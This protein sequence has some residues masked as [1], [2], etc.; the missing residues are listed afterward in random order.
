MGISGLIPILKDA[1]K[2]KHISDYKGQ[3][4]AV[5]AYVLLHRGAF[6][7]APDLVKI[8]LIEDIDKRNKSLT[9]LAPKF[10]N[11]ALHQIKAMLHFKIKPYIV[12]DGGP[13]GAK[14][15]TED[16]RESN[17][18]TNLETALKLESQGKLSQARSAFTKCVDITPRMAFELIKVLKSMNVDYI[19]APYEADAQMY[20]LERVGLVDGILT[21]DS[22]LLVFGSK[23]VIFKLKQDG[24][25]DEIS[26]DRF[27]LVRIDN[28][29]MCNGKWTDTHFRRMA[30]LSGCDYLKSL[31]GIGLKTAFE[32]IRKGGETFEMIFLYFYYNYES[33]GK[34]IP[35]DYKF[36][37]K[38]AELAF[39]HQRVY[40]PI[41]K[42]L[43]PLNPLP[44][45][46][47][48]CD[49]VNDWI[50]NDL[51]ESLAQSIAKGD[52]CPITK[53]NFSTNGTYQNIDESH[54]NVNNNNKK[55]QK[56]LYDFFQKKPTGTGNDSGRKTFN[57]VVNKKNIVKNENSNETI[58][59]NVFS[60]YF[61]AIANTNVNNNNKRKSMNDNNYDD[62]NNNNKVNTFISI[63]DNNDTINDN[64]VNCDFVSSPMQEINTITKPS[65]F[66]LT[67]LNN[68]DINVQVQTPS[69]KMKKSSSS[70]SSLMNIKVNSPNSNKLEN[71]LEGIKEENVNENNNK[72][73]C[74]D[75]QN[76][77]DDDH[78]E[79]ENKLNYTKALTQN[80]RQK[81]SFNKQNNQ[82]P[83]LSSS[84][85]NFNTYDNVK[86][87]YN[88]FTPKSTNKHQSFSQLSTPNNH[89]QISSNLLSS[90][91]N[92]SSSH[93]KLL[94]FAYKAPQNF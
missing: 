79:N 4:L 38:L 15:S 36:K 51:D 69:K 42:K 12:F 22:D 6:A 88:S 13:L 60:P 30:M 32:A 50:G 2:S 46:M 75:S 80:W 27:G 34:K 41:E 37:F 29:P 86:Q 68:K 33:K 71:L 67:L 61:Q 73:L 3:S 93:H 31:P 21:E 44:K 19:V 59:E 64:D 26:R 24:T 82:K 77:E 5:D 72:V 14:L 1:S 43:K 58:K 7:C 89:N 85:S 91:N 90:S 62:S 40:C 66:N 11:Y 49:I 76:D 18:K 83:I 87:N 84:P 53:I 52:I 17:R 10:L 25:C 57:D 54:Q 48:D 45:D 23:K 9:A 63:D 55:P 74:Y 39:L 78:D 47:I 92:T 65:G 8:G 94:N 56:S 28:I 16:I 35:S 70:N 81:F 20:H